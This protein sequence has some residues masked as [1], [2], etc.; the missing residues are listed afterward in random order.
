MPQHIS[1][2]ENSAVE[3]LRRDNQQLRKFLADAQESAAKAASRGKSMDFAHLLELVKEFST[4]LGG[5]AQQDDVN[6]EYDAA[7]SM[8]T[9][10]F[11]LD[12]DDEDERDVHLQKLK[13]KVAAAKSDL[14]RASVAALRA[15]PDSSDEESDS[16]SEGEEERSDCRLKVLQG[17]AGGLDGYWMSRKTGHRQ[18]ISSRD[19]S[20]RQTGCTSW[21]AV[22][23]NAAS[24]TVNGRDGQR[25]VAERLR[26]RM[27]G[28]VLLWD[29][30][31]MWTRQ[32]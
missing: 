11:R 31:E 19:D 28:E 24:L 6:L 26:T 8:N 4:D 16:D 27:L 15:E 12:A 7:L 17:P 25:H 3:I 23:S 5:S 10:Q 2:S 18:Y 29:S 13:A 30:G 9:E 22:E 20:R 14:A 32:R 21:H 1:T